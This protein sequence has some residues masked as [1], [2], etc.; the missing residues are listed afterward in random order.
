[1]EPSIFTLKPLSLVP[2]K[3]CK[4]NKHLFAVC[5]AM[6]VLYTDT[7]GFNT[8]V[9]PRYLVGSRVQWKTEEHNTFPPDSELVVTSDFDSINSYLSFDLSY[10]TAALLF[11]RLLHFFLLV[12]F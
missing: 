9:I 5:Q 11:W 7:F 1:M 12:F 3:A 8:T 6:K 10:D 2:V 4:D